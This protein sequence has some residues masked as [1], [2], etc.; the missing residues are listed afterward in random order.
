MRVD[1][2]YVYEEEGWFQ[3][4]PPDLPRPWSYIQISTEN[5]GAGK[6]IECFY[7]FSA[8]ESWKRWGFIGDETNITPEAVGSSEPIQFKF[9]LRTENPKEAPGVKQIRFDYPPTPLKPSR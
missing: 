5:T 1:V 4:A 3:T 8:N 9:H 6:S 7:R 2:E